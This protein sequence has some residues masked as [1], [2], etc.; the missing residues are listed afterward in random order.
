MS[1]GVPGFRDRV[2]NLRTKVSLNT[3][4][5]I[6]TLIV[7][8]VGWEVAAKTGII[9]P[10]FFPP[11]TEIG[12][13]FVE[14]YRTGEFVDHITISMWRI[15]LGFGLGAVTG[16]AVGLLM[17]ASRTIR[18]FVDPWVSILY[19]FPKIV[20]LPIFFSLFGI[21]EEARILTI[22]LSVFLLVAINSMAGVIEIEQVYFDVARDNNAGNFA[23]YRNVILPGS[24]PHVFTGLSLGMGLAFILIVVIEMVG[25][26]SGL[27]YVIWDSW[28]KFTITRMYVAIITI[29]VFGIVYTYGID[30]LGRALTP[31][32]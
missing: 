2:A 24:L 16:V 22:A 15:S 19:P 26:D 7:V 18:S 17:G 20:L 10:Q 32:N 28:E 8:V 9:T 27:G 29:N 1:V 21:G 11:P 30:W 13:G 12:G 6:T 14:L 4:I 3:A 31:W 5:S 25:A 23:V